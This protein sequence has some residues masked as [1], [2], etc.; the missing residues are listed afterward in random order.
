M[1]WW[2]YLFRKYKYI[3]NSQNIIFLSKLF[4]P[5][6]ANILKVDLATD[7]I[8]LT[9]IVVAHANI[10]ANHMGHCARQK[11]RLIHIDIHADADGPG[12][13]DSLGHGHASLAPGERFPAVK[14]S[15]HVHMHII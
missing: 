15:E 8:I 4:W 5:K 9:P 7:L 3:W 11:V 2:F 12:R 13:A 14:T 10:V 6:F 1:Y